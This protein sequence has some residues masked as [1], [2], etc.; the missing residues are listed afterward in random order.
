MMSDKT[1][2]GGMSALIEDSMQKTAEMHEPKIR[3]H[4]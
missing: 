4:I 3:I 2:A 1:K